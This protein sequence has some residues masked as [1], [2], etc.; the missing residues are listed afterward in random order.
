MKGG[1]TSNEGRLNR[2]ECWNG[3]MELE[4]RW[5]LPDAVPEAVPGAVPLRD[6]LLGAYAD[7]RRH[8]H[9]VRHLRDVLDRLDELE[10]HG[11]A[12]DPLTVRLAAWFHDAVYDAR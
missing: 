11:V 1:S 12:F 10:A 4:G 5:P 6:R 3:G 2:S 7:P 8:Y 9:D